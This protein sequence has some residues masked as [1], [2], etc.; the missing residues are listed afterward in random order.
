MS[1]TWCFGS[2]RMF[3]RLVSLLHSYIFF[4]ASVYASQKTKYHQNWNLSAKQLILI[5]F[6]KFSIFV[7][8]ILLS[9]KYR[10]HNSMM[11]T[12]TE[13]IFL[14]HW[15]MSMLYESNRCLSIEIFNI[16][17]S[18]LRYWLLKRSSFSFD[19]ENNCC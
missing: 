8:R 9:I 1:Q 18:R 19:L 6:V 2:T 10:I 4:F 16:S 3:S 5:K 13:T 14:V 15:Q 17:G 12:V 11:F 7:H